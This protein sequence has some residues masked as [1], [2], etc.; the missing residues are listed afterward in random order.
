MARQRKPSIVELL[1][2]TPK[3]VSTLG[4]SISTVRDD[5]E[6]LVEK[7]EA[8]V[9]IHAE[10]AAIKA[11]QFEE[12]ESECEPFNKAVFEVEDAAERLVVLAKDLM[13]QCKALRS[14][15]VEEW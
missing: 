10:R 3:A 7:F 5:Q 1:F 2:R 8:L 4:V 15:D 11:R 9:R 12:G 13:E 6:A 14:R